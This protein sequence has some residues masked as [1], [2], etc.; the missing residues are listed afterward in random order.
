M[1]VV[2]EYSGRKKRYRY[3]KN[4]T[5]TNF[6]NREKYWETQQVKF[7]K[8]QLINQGGAVCGICGEPI[9]DMKDC[10]VDHI[11][12]KSKGGQTTIEN[13]QLAHW[14]CNNRKGDAYDKI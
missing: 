8:R 13:C 6:K 1:S 11:R 14:E 2:S 5:F 9:T 10:T 4:K 12:P 3:H 7:I